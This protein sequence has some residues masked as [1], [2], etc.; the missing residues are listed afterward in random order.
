MTYREGWMMLQNCVYKLSVISNKHLLVITSFHTW[1][2]H[3]NCRRMSCHVCLLSPV[4]GLVH[5]Q[6]SALNSYWY[7]LSFVPWNSVHFLSVRELINCN[8]LQHSTH[9]QHA[10]LQLVTKT[11]NLII[12][13]MYRAPSGDINEFLKRLDATLKYL[14][15]P[16]SKVYNLWWHKRKLLKWKQS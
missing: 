13:S 2:K 10:T 14:Y 15:S 12:L 8:I 16:K 6:Q 4:P 1:S 11:S 9:M 7:V 3:H 5:V